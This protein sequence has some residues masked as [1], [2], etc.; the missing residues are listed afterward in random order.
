MICIADPT[1]TRDY[2]FKYDGRDFDPEA[3]VQFHHLRH[4]DLAVGRWISDQPVGCE[5]G[6]IKLCR[7]VDVPLG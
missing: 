5:T 1:P 4:F 3:G 7:Y 6:D 2:I